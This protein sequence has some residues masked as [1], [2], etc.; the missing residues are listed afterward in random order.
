MPQLKSYKNC[1]FFSY[2]ACPH[3]N[4]ELMKRATQDIPQYYGGNYPTLSFPQDEEID[5]KCSKC[6][7][8]TQK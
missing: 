2:Q 3:K 8:Y 1:K 6:N 7:K 5:A 4:E